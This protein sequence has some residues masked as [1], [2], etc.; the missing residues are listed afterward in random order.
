MARG[1]RGGGGRACSSAACATMVACF[2]VAASSLTTSFDT[3]SRSFFIIPARSLCSFASNSGFL[4]SGSSF[5]CLHRA[6]RVSDC[7]W[8]KRHEGCAPAAL[9]ALEAGQQSGDELDELHDRF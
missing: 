2:L 3:T 9:A 5:S 8:C 7:A 4:S 6:A 1:G